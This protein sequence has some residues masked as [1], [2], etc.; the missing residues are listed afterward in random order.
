MLLHGVGK[1]IPNSLPL[2]FLHFSKGRHSFV[3]LQGYGLQNPFSHVCEPAHSL[4]D[5]EIKT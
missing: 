1:Q 4:S 3:V 5:L 2:D